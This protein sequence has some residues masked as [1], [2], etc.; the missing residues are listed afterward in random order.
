MLKVIPSIEGT[1]PCPN[2]LVALDLAFPL[3]L[4]LL[5]MFLFVEIVQLLFIFRSPTIT[6]ATELNT[7]SAVS[8]IKANG[9]FFL[10]SKKFKFARTMIEFRLKVFSTTRLKHLL[11]FKRNGD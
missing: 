4:T 1:T 9:L 2:K 11:I 7:A 3:A 5:V 6:Q 10:E 8:S